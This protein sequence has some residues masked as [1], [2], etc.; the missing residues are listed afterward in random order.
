VEKFKTLRRR[1]SQRKG[2]RR[3]IRNLFADGVKMIVKN[4]YQPKGGKE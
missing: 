3:E 1:N 2:V 4:E